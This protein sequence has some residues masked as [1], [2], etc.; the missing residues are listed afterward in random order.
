[1][2]LCQKHVKVNN[3][4]SNAKIS[5]YQGLYPTYEHKTAIN[6]TFTF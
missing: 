4:T 6:L 3:R 1:M 5:M 2:L